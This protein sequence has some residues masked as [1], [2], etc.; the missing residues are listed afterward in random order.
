MRGGVSGGF[1]ETD[2]SNVVDEEIIVGRRTS[3]YSR[4]EYASAPVELEPMRKR[5]RRRRRR[6]IAA[7]EREEDENHLKPEQVHLSISGDE[8][9]TVV[10]TTR[11]P[12]EEDFE[13]RYACA[14]R[15]SEDEEE[16][17]MIDRVVS[18]KTQTT[19][20]IG[21]VF[22]SSSYTQ[23]MCL[24]SATS[25]TAPSMGGPKT[26]VKRDV[27]AK[28]A[29]TSSWADRDASNYNVVNSF[30]D[31]VPDAWRNRGKRRCVW[32]TQTPTAGGIE[33]RLYTKRRL[34]I[35]IRK[36]ALMRACMCYRTT[37]M[38]MEK[39]STDRL[40]NAAVVIP[41]KEKQYSPSWEI[42]DKPK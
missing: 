21:K 23:Q 9:V 42:P 5:R 25:L 12:L 37:R 2:E 33:V 34:K 14:K 16:K 6:L 40:R 15:N 10:W 3:F 41:T 28:L 18:S 36:E 22:E 29:N 8:E 39:Q 32:G 20:H 17:D 27:L 31:V 13:V 11:E 38:R 7:D 26:P 4:P 1:D 30:K 35:S 19:W 24:A